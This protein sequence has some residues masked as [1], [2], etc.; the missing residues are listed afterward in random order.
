MSWNDDY[1]HAASRLDDHI[2]HARLTLCGLSAC[3]DAMVSLHDAQALLEATAPAEAVEFAGM[4]VARAK[5]GIGGEIRVDW[6]GGPDWLDNTLAFRHLPGGTG[7]HAARILTRLGAPALLA[8]ATRSPEQMAALDPGLHLAHEG[9]A[10]E[11]AQ[12]RP[13]QPNANKIY[14]F[15]FSAGRALDG[16]LLKR[17]S[18]IIVR[19]DDPG[20]EDDSEYNALSAR[21]ARNAGAGVLSGY[22][23]VGRGDLEGALARTRRLV[24]EWRR[25]GTFVIHLELAGYECDAYRD[26]VLEGL[27]GHI[28]SLGLSLSEYE[29][30]VPPDTSLA[31][32]MFDLA[33]RLHLQRICVHADNWAASLTTGDATQ[34]RE[35]LLAGCLLASS[36]AATGQVSKPEGASAEAIFEP[37][38]ELPAS[39]GGRSFVAVSAPYVARPATTL[40]LG[41]T[42]MAGCLLVLGQDDRPRLAA[43][44]RPDAAITA[45]THES[46]E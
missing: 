5:A 40:G 3:V 32:G 33:V 1:R 37:P 28:T 21:L 18:R 19:F 36:R 16:A 42:F 31:T 39:L 7:P 43:W 20:L 11:I 46:V 27:S 12:L 44:Q 9:Q 26:A 38:P 4:L 14:I 30:L 8:L 24:G 10:V 15:E 17:S 45:A 25:Q 34:E 2:A 23:C 22:N 41:D 13:T 35:A 29:A 6:P